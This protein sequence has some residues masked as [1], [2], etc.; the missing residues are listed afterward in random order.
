MS[1]TVETLIKIAEAEVGYLEKASN[2]QLDDKTAN[3]GSNNYTKYARDFD[4]KYEK[5]LKICKDYL[6]FQEIIDFI[7]DNFKEIK[8]DERE[9]WV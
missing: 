5:L 8:V 7:C 2:S 4:E 3:A 1:Y 9:V 6:D